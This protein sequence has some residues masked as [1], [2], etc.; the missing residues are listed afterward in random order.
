M[1]ISYTP[2]TRDCKNREE[3]IA[4]PHHTDQSQKELHFD[5]QGDLDLQQLYPLCFSG[6]YLIS[7]AKYHF[8]KNRKPP[9]QANLPKKEYI[10]P[11]YDMENWDDPNISQTMKYNTL[12][13]RDVPL[14]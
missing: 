2:H 7:A 10:T 9:I 8:E 6:V 5:K 13:T 4:T 14:P 3:Y 11:R 12:S 1:C